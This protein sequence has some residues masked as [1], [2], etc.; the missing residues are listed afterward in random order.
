[1]AKIA[2]FAEATKRFM[3]LSD[4]ELITDHPTYLNGWEIPSGK[5]SFQNQKTDPVYGGP[6]SDVWRPVTSDQRWIIDQSRDVRTIPKHPFE[7]ALKRTPRP[8]TD[9]ERRLFRLDLL[10]SHVKQD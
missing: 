10:D 9:D 1:M 6:D 3:F 4:T 2:G 8:L 5:L 7:E